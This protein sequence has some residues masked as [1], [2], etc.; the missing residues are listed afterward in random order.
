MVSGDFVLNVET[1]CTLF[2]RRFSWKIVENSKNTV[3]AKF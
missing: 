3:M 1:P 2:D